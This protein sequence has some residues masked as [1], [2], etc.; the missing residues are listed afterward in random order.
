MVNN[1][2]MK[3]VQRNFIKIKSEIVQYTRYKISRSLNANV[4]SPTINYIILHYIVIVINCIGNPH[5]NTRRNKFLYLYN[6]Y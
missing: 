3:R 2:N 1:W 4:V 5:I 6:Y